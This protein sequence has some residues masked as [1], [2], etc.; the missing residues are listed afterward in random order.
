MKKPAILGGEPAF[1][2][3]LHV[4]RPN[5]PDLAT[6][7]KLVDEMFQ[8]RWFTNFGPLA[9][10]LQLE[11]QNLLQVKHCIPLCNGTVALELACRAIGLTGEVIVPSYTFIATAHAL[12]WQE[13]TPVFCDMLESDFT[14]DPDKIEELITEKTTGI[15]GVHVYGNPCNYKAISNIAKKY[16]LKVIYDAAH[17]FTN[18]VKGIPICQLGDISVLSF[19]ATKFFSTFEGGAVATDN[20]DLAEKIQ[21]MMNFGFAGKEKDKVDFIGTNGKMTEICSAM[22]LAMLDK[23]EAIREVN[24]RN[25]GS[26]RKH[27]SGIDGITLRY[28]SRDLTEQNWQYIIITIDEN[29]FGLS[30]DDLIDV[31]NAENV[32]ARRYFYPGCHKMQPYFNSFPNK[33]RVLALTDQISETVISL[34]TGESVND[35]SIRII[36]EVIKVASAQADP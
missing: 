26:Y 14:I 15:I 10:Q 35:K 23:V 22:G 29:I 28:P 7:N 27:L 5:L 32:L 9:K 1:K 17:A 36:S 13:I 21:L 11:L 18:K 25:F 33:G 31:L 3:P 8:R 34:P 6:F 19:H 16:N 4:G 12:K 20:D 2:E 30:R 24:E